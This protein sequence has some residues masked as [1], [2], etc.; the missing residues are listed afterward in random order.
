MVSA[1]NV[2][3]SSLNRPKPIVTY[4]GGGKVWMSV[5]EIILCFS[6][7]KVYIVVNII[8]QFGQYNFYDKKEY[9]SI[10]GFFCSSRRLGIILVLVPFAA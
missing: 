10:H 5:S 8:I 3:C 7:P 9:T 4:W 2:T 1:S 6:E